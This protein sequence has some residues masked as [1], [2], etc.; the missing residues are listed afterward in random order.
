M[1]IDC[2]TRKSEIRVCS[3]KKKKEEEIVIDICESRI[4]ESLV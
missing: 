2:W 4:V 1:E 3:E